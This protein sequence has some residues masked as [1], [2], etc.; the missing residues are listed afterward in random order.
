MKKHNIVIFRRTCILL[1]QFVQNRKPS[2]S[3]GTSVY[4]CSRSD[5]TVS[6]WRFELTSSPTVIPSRDAAVTT[7][8]VG[9]AVVTLTRITQTDTTVNVTATISYSDTV[10]LNG[11]YMECNGDRLHI[12]ANLPSK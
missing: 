11:I 7:V 12:S 5:G 8:N 10:L 3:D 1:G 9:S 6:N 2:C 4:Y